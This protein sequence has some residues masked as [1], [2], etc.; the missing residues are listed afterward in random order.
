MQAGADARNGQSIPLVIGASSLGTLFEWYDF[1]I[2]GALAASGIIGRTFFPSDSP[3]LQ[4]LLSWAGFAVGFGFRPLGAIVFGYLGDRLGRKHTFMMTIVLMGL[5]TAGVGLVPSAASIGVAAPIL[6]ILLRVCQGLALGGEYGGAAIYVAEHAPRGRAGFYTSFIQAAVAGGFVLSLIVIL[7]I[8]GLMSAQSWESW[9]W[10]IPFLLSL[11]LLAISVWMRAKLSESPVFAR[12]KARGETA[13][14]PFVESFT[15]PGNVRRLFVA[16]IGVS[17]AFTVIWYTG[18]F[19]ALSFLQGPM[20]IEG[21]TAQIVVAAA[22]SIGSVFFIWSGWLSDR[23][24]RVRVMA[25]SYILALVLLFPIF[26]FLGQQASPALVAAN[27]RAPIGVVGPDCAYSPFAAKQADACATL[28]ADLTAKGVAYTRS[29]GPDLVVTIGAQRLE[30]PDVAR[31][32]AAMA[33]AGYDFTPHVPTGR[34]LAFI[35]LGVLALTFLGGLTY[36][37]VAAL[38][39]EM[40]PPAVRYSSMSIPYHIG[41]GY[42]GGFLPF[43]A[44]Y[45]TARSGDPYAGLWYTIAVVAVGLPVLLLGLRGHDKALRGR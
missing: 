1:F 20:K 14:N 15:F 7:S 38:L 29:A 39:C 6:I 23:I 17:A 21:T 12:M 18:M 9:G 37:P 2:Y 41:T 31:L 5:A 10:R 8:K 24:G 45:L 42:F 13:R 33:A 43:I 26:W 19:Y 4:T 35:F 22:A 11:A 44:S 40:F 3:T 25:A 34:R 32:D 16:L 27:A 36:G 28:L 30:A